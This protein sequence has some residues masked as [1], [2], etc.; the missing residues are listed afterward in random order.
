VVGRMQRAPKWMQD[1][2]LEWLFRLIKQ[3]SRWR[4]MLQLPRFVFKI[5]GAKR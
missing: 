1:A 3:P 5:Y 2:K 4:R